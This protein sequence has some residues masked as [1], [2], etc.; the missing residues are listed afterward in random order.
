MARTFSTPCQ[1]TLY[2]PYYF[3]LDPDKENDVDYAS[4]QKL[5]ALTGGEFHYWHYDSDSTF[6]EVFSQVL[7]SLD[8]LYCTITYTTDN[9]TDSL[10]ALEL[11]G[12]KNCAARVVDRHQSEGVDTWEGALSYRTRIRTPSFAHLQMI[13]MMCRGMMIADLVAILA[14]IDFVMADV[15][16]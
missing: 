8:S 16:R 14:S 2:H 7:H 4:L 3:P 10:A 5:A 6:G 9:C 1:V 11:T 12:A 15:D 13:P